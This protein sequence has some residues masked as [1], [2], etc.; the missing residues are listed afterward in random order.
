VAIKVL[1]ADSSTDPDRLKRFEQE[2]R[3]A[4]A[5]NHPNLVAVFDTGVHEGGALH[6]LRAAA[7][8]VP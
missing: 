4:G 1:P 8:P 2:S 7:R 6:R 3:A 5:L